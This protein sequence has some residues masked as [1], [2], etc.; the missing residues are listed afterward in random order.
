MGSLINMMFQR[1]STGRDNLFQKGVSHRTRSSLG[2]RKGF[3]SCE[4]KNLC[5]HAKSLQPC[6][7]GAA[8]LPIAT[9]FQQAESY[10]FIQ[11]C[12]SQG[13]N[14]NVY[15]D[16]RYAAPTASENIV[17]AQHVKANHFFIL[18]PFK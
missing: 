15:V 12:F 3:S 11:V 8:S 14:A 1:S 17:I 16:S 2:A 6:L 4:L 10:A 9:S 18:S 13:Q 5:I 7:T